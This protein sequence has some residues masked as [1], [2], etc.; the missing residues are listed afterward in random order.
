[1]NKPKHRSFVVSC[2]VAALGLCFLGFGVE[3]ASAEVIFLRSGNGPIGGPD[4]QI[5]MLVGTGATPLS[6]SLFTPAD[7]AAACNGRPAIVINP[8]PAWLQQLP[9][10]LA[11]QWIGTDPVG[12]PASA[13]YCH[14]FNVQTCCI[15]SALLKFCWAGDDALGDGIYGGPN[16]DGVYINGTPVVPS[17]NTGS[18]AAP[19]SV[20]GVD[21]TAL[22]HCGSNQLQIYNRDAALVVSGVIYQAVLDITECSVP[23]EGATFGTVKSLYK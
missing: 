4:T 9:C 18:Y 15:Q 11:A 20:G 1:M 21:V 19:T 13:L 22:L 12:T 5:N 6:A 3:R 8:H 14:T 10:D 23:G 16:L 2:L 7:F 17:I